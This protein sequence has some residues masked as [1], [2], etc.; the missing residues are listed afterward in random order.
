MKITPIPYANIYE[1]ECDLDLLERAFTDIKSHTFQWSESESDVITGNFSVSGYLDKKNKVSWYHEEL[2]NWMQDCVDQVANTTIKV[3]LAIND[4][5]VTKT[6]YKQISTVHR[7]S[8][9]VFSG[10]LYFSEHKSSTIKFQYSD[11]NRERFGGLFVDNTQGILEYAPEK[12]KFLVFPSDLYHSI[13][14]HTDPKTTR[15][16][17]AINTF[18]NGKVEDIVTCVLQNNVITVKDRFLQWKDQQDKI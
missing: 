17:L 2:F 13:K 11:H 4:S 5:W 14:V 7:H 16:S 1:F 12:G 15:Y 9:S 3:P 8:W 18:F 10:V 6:K